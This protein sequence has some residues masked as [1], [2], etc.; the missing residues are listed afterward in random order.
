M[1][2]APSQ[3]RG[4]VAAQRLR[5]ITGPDLYRRNPFRVAGLATNAK[6]AQVRAQRHLLLGRA[7][8]RQQHGSR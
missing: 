5:E 1:T 2:A 4:R 3:N 7:R 6:P 8:A